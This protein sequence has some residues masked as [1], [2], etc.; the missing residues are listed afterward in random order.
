MLLASVIPIRIVRVS[1]VTG[2]GAIERSEIAGGVRSPAVIEIALA[3][4]VGANPVAVS[5]TLI[6][7]V[8]DI[9]DGMTATRHDAVPTAPGSSTDGE[10]AACVSPRIDRNPGTESVAN[11]PARVSAE[12][13][14]RFIGN[15]SG[16]KLVQ[17]SGTIC[18]GCV[19][20][21]D[22]VPNDLSAEPM[23]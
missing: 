10:I 4:E 5:S 11:A 18:A 17:P 12:L 1:R 23:P 7:S 13:T 3:T 15:V 22:T 6:E 14:R 9:D 2:V 19:S 16:E 21:S 20:E 8:H